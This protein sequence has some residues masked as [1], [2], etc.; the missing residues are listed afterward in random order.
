MQGKTTQSL[1]C[2]YFVIFIVTCDNNSQDLTVLV[3][4]SDNIST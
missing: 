2:I 1:Q 3:L 4:L